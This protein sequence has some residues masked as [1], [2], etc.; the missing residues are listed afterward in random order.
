MG[1]RN[2]WKLPFAALAAAGLAGYLYYED[3]VLKTTR[4]SICNDRIPAA[5]DGY[6]IVHISDFHNTKNRP[7]RKALLTSIRKASPDLIVITG[8]L[9]DKRRTDI[10]ASVSFVKSIADFAPVYYVCG[11][12]DVCLDPYELLDTLLRQLKDA[13]VHVL[14]N[15]EDEI[16]RQ[17]ET[18]KIAGVKDPAILH[19]EQPDDVAI[20]NGFLD[21]A[22]QKDEG[23]RI[24]LAH[25]PDLLPL[26]AEKG[27]DIVFCGHAHGGQVRL[28][29]F[30]AVIAP[31]QG[32]FPTYSEGVYTEKDTF[33]VV[34]RGIGNSIIPFRV[35]D[36]P[37]LVV[38]VLKRIDE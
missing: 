1:A 22:L 21:E 19:E 11:N 35:N 17:G 23:F 18:I 7:L 5:F 9:V 8:D 31:D 28:P 37:E 24:L 27:V 4:Y 34:S 33:M 20:M 30:G 14:F 38:T 10:D 16:S 3:T 32:Y 29:F 25:R 15:A 26:Y 2:N 12:H 36:R 13:G 6:T